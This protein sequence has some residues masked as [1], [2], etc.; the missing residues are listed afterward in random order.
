MAVQCPPVPIDFNTYVPSKYGLFSVAKPFPNLDPHWRTCG[1]TFTSNACP[2]AE[3]WIENCTSV[4]LK[5]PGSEPGLVVADPFT[6]YSSWSCGVFGKTPEQ[7][8]TDAENALLCAEEREVEAL[9]FSGSAANTP[10]LVGGG[11]T[12]LNTTGTPVSL[13]AGIGALE[14]AMASVQCGEAT[15]HLPRELGALAARFHQ[16]YGSGNMLRSALG[17]PMAFGSGYGNASPAGVAPP[18]GIAWIYITGPVYLAQT[19]VFM[20]P[21]TFEDAL[22][23]TNNQLVWEANRTNL[24]AVDGCACFAVAV[25]LNGS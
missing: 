24:L 14:G 19:E 21:P 11:C 5:I 22:D 7:H 15:L 2:A 10:Q 12:A 17:S 8:R 16:T 4:P 20:N 3:V 9:F 18:A 1:V 6:I 23:R 13:A 25:S